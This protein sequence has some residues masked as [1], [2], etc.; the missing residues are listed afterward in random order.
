MISNTDPGLAGLA[1]SAGEAS[2]R[3]RIQGLRK[4]VFARHAAE[5]DREGRFPRESIEAL[6][7]ARLLNATVPL[8][9]GG[10]GANITATVAM[11]E[12]AAKGC[13]ST[14]MVMA[15]HYS[16]LPLL[17]AKASATQTEKLLGGVLRGDTLLAIAGSEAGAGTRIW[18]LDGHAAEDGDSYRLTAMKSFVTASGHADFLVVPVRKSATASPDQLS[19]FWVPAAT[20]GVERLGVWDAMGLRGNDSRPIRLTGAA[21]PRF[22]RLGDDGDGF[23]FLSAIYMPHYFLAL[24]A[25]YL[26]VAAAAMDAAVEHVKARVHSDT[27]QALSQVE[28]IQR[29]IGTMKATL[30]PVRSALYRCARYADKALSIWQE[31]AKSGLLEETARRRLNDPFFAEVLAVKVSVCEAA[32]AVADTA[33]QVCGGRGFKRGALVERAYRDVRAGSLMA[34]SDDVAKLMIGRQLLGLADLW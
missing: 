5:V 16:L 7:A 30:D 34:P 22:H 3:R 32:R 31:V 29:Q 21:V 10:P 14:A 18:H 8:H 1:L 27:A 17:F 2:L 12:E 33:L 13:S 9:A 26:G 15:M 20:A 19:L 6:R 25:T 4:E 24:A 28:T 23:G 11:I